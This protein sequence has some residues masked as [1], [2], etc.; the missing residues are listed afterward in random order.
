MTSYHPSPLPQPPIGHEWAPTLGPNGVGLVLIN[1]TATKEDNQT[2]TSAYH[3]V[4]NWSN[5]ERATIVDKLV[6]L[7]FTIL[8]WVKIRDDLGLAGIKVTLESQVGR[9]HNGQAKT[10]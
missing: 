9:N 7:A 3:K 8:D 4:D 1:S 6:G 5:L 10:T 2:V